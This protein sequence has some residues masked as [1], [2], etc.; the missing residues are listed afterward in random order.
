M[1]WSPPPHPFPPLPSCTTLPCEVSYEQ[2]PLYNTRLLGKR[3]RP[4]NGLSGPDVR[5][6]SRVQFQGSGSIARC[7]ALSMYEG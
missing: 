7:R 2:P 3:R 6:Y 5:L 4:L 1:R